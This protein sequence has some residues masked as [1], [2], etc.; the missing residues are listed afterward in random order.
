[1]KR[2]IKNDKSIDGEFEYIFFDTWK[3]VGVLGNEP[4]VMT[5]TVSVEIDLVREIYQTLVSNGWRKTEK[6]VDKKREL[7]LQYFKRV[8][9]CCIS[10]Q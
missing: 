5:T 2:F 6:S 7:G 3:I 9:K 8:G 1:V 10:S 4:T